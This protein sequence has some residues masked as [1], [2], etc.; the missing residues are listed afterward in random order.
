[1]INFLI[2]LISFY[3]SDATQVKDSVPLNTP[4]EQ[5]LFVAGEGSYH[6]YRIPSLLVAEDGSVLAFVEGRRECV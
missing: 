2:Y 5:D 6:T 1:M 4:M 3:F